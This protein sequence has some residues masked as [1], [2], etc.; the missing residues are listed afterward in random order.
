VE[1]EEYIEEN[2]ENN[3]SDIESV[4][5]DSEEST[6]QEDIEIST[7]SND[8]ELLSGDSQNDG[9]EPS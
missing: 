8:A 9:S 3:N 4:S 7:D 5:V 2:T 1:E 6:E